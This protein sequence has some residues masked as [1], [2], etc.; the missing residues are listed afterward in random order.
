MGLTISGGGHTP[1]TNTDLL[2][3]GSSSW[4]RTLDFHSKD[5]GFESPTRYQDKINVLRDGISKE[6]FNLKERGET[7][8][9]PWYCLQV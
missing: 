7:Q 8:E 3:A 4:P 6:H 1:M 9:A 2:M 5:Q